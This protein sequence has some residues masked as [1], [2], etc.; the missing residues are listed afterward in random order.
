MLDINKGFRA[1]IKELVF[2][3]FFWQVR[4]RTPRTR[5]ASILEEPAS[6]SNIGKLKDK[7]KESTLGCKLLQKTEPFNDSI[8]SKGGKDEEGVCSL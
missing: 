2:L 6:L 1:I 7:M 8:I 4:T 3:V 5:R